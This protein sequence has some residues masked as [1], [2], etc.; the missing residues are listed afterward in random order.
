[1]ASS[2]TRVHEASNAHTAGAPKNFHLSSFAFIK[3]ESIENA[4]S[5]DVARGEQKLQTSLRNYHW[6][7]GNGTIL[8]FGLTIRPGGSG[9]RR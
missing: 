1:M 7:S 3:N 8:R 2:K 6:S 9:R 4:P 5:G